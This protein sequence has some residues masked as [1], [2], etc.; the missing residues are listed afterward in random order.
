MKNFGLIFWSLLIVAGVLMVMT[1]NRLENRLSGME[2]QIDEMNL[3]L[4]D[5]TLSDE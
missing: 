4:K 5:M 1:T 2:K 3:M